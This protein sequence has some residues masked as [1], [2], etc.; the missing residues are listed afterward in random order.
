LLFARWSHALV[1]LVKID[2][3]SGDLRFNIIRAEY[4]FIFVIFR[5]CDADRVTVVDD[6]HAVRFDIAFA[7][8]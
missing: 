8:D 3:P 2:L 6:S 5:R 7:V 1:W 4:Q